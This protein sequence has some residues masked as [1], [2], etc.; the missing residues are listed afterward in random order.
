M[1][2]PDTVNEDSK[3]VSAEGDT[4]PDN[5]RFLFHKTQKKIKLTQ[6]TEQQ[7]HSYS[8]GVVE[9]SLTHS[10]SP[11]RVEIKET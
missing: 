9:K 6:S 10:F 8:G 1:R 4:K 3:D 11:T 7:R 5:Q 2:Q